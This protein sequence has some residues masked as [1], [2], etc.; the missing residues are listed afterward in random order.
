MCVS[1]SLCGET[2]VP[3]SAGRVFGCEENRLFQSVL[4]Y[5]IETEEGKKNLG[6]SSSAALFNDATL[7]IGARPGSEVLASM[8]DV[9][10][11][12]ALCDSARKDT[13]PGGALHLA[14]PFAQAEYAVDI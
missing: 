1:T 12:S 7:S 9:S 6:R 3:P 2:W 13:Q 5:R 8:G 11:Q 4:M 10:L 14:P